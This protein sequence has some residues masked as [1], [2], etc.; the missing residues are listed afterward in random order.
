MVTFC[1][2][3]GVS[4]G[5]VKEMRF[6]AVKDLVIA[7]GEEEWNN[8]QRIKLKIL[9]DNQ[10]PGGKVLPPGLFFS[11]SFVLEGWFYL[12]S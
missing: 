12:L 1:G 9:L 3:M 8:R 6:P 4:T 11:S 7:I 5:Y 2:S 10:K